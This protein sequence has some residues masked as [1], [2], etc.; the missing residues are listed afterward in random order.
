MNYGNFK[1]QNIS[2][3]FAGGLGIGIGILILNYTMAQ[4]RYEEP[5]EPIK[6]NTYTISTA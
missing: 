2:N 1:T 5:V 4:S 6:R 3:L